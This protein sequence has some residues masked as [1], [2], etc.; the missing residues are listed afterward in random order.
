MLPHKCEGAIK[1]VARKPIIAGN[2]KMNKGTV[3]EATE[4]VQSLLPL[5]EGTNG[6]DVI[7]CPP[8]PV[9]HT[10]KQ[11]LGESGV[12]L[13]AQNVYWKA[14]GAYTGEVS[15]EMLLD[16]GVEYAIIGHSERRGR[17]GVA[18]PD[19]TE[20]ILKHFGETDATVNRKVTAALAA[21]LI[22]IIC[23]GETLVERQSN[24]TDALIQAQV[25]A[26]LDGISAAQAAGLVF[27]YE[28]VWA[29][30]TGET[31]SATEA[32]RVCGIVRETVQS[33]YDTAT[34][35][36]VRIQYGGSMKPDNA[37]DLLDG[38]E[39]DGGLI[40]GASL[41]AADFAAIVK[42]AAALT[43]AE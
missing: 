30:G 6:V 42:A 9:L 32:N 23:V 11:L 25:E 27:A 28:P 37:A 24:H 26:A 14:A 4:L 3:R 36:S 38:S 39:V 40:G 19:F 22:P 1:Q 18:E 5:L 17:F 21:G 16:A 12:A 7:V 43:S 20:G 10:V 35:Q 15:S 33:L 31:C 13:G 8:F 41:K 34:A 2:W 29:I